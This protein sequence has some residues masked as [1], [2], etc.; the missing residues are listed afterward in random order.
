MMGACRHST[1][2]HVCLLLVRVV[3]YVGGQIRQ[4]PCKV[5][6]CPLLV[7]AI[8]VVCLGRFPIQDPAVRIFSSCKDLWAL[9]GIQNIAM[10]V[11]HTC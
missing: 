5:G 10:Y 3:D 1:V 2:P 8:M 4:Q 6:L 9:V 7:V 11:S